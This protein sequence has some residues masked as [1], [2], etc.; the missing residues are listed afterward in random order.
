MVPPGRNFI[1]RSYKYHR[2]GQKCSDD[3][4]YHAQEE[5]LRKKAG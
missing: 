5:E 4:T 1:T 3:G 2:Y